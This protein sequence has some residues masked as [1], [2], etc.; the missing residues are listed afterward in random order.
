M[1]L[2]TRPFREE[3]ERDMF[4]ENVSAHVRRVLTATVEALWAQ[5]EADKTLND[6][7]RKRAMSA[8]TAGAT[9]AAADALK[10]H[11]ARRS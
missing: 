9:L 5:V 6:A 8:V 7:Q 3:P 4:S 11:M 1:M 10:Q 2:N